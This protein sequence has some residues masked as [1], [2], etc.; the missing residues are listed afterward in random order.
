MDG[1]K[2]CGAEIHC[3]AKPPPPPAPPPLPHLPPWHWALPPE[4]I[5]FAS[6]EGVL[7]ANGVPFKIK[8]VNWFGSEGR[9]GPPLGLDRHDIA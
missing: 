1:C 9:S 6:H 5:N 7:L 3:P 4:F 8:G 2:S